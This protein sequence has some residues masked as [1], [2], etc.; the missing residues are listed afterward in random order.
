M[1]VGEIQ[2]FIV[3]IFLNLQIYKFINQKNFENAKNI[4]YWKL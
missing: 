3:Q 2:I 1:R 4:K